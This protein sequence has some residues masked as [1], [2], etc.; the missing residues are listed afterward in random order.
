[1]ESPAKTARQQTLSACDSRAVAAY[2]LPVLRCQPDGNHLIEGLLDLD[3]N[4]LVVV[5][6]AIASFDS[7]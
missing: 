5:A 7:P 6:P 4:H 1:M 3:F 2:L